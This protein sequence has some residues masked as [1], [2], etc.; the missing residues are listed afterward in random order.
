MSTLT[1]VPLPAFGQAEE[2]PPLPA[3]LYAGRLA[4]ARARMAEDGLDALVV[5]GDRE[6]FA[7]LAYLTGFD[8]RFEEALLLLDRDGAGKL[9]VGNECMGYLPD[10]ALGLDVELFQE[11]SLLGQPRAQ[12]RPLRNILSSFGIRRGV[13]V[14]C[15]GW[16]YFDSGLIAG[17]EEEEALDVP[18]Y[19]ADLLRG[20]CGV[21]K[22]VVNATAL[23]MNPYDGLRVVN[24][25]EQIAQFE[26][27]ATV[28]SAGVLDLLRHLAPGARE[29]NLERFLDSRGLPLSC[30][31][32]IG[33]GDKARRGLASASARRAVLGDVFTVAFGVTGGLTCRAGCIAR[34]LQDLSCELRNFYPR[35]AANYFDV[36][37]A[38]YGSLRVGAAGCGVFT[39]VESRRDA[40]LYDFAV[41]P[42]HFIHLDE[43]VH[44]P[45]CADGRTPLRSGM[46]L[47]AD[48]IPV[49]RGPFCYANAE[50]GVV[51]ADAALRAV[52][53]RQFPEMWERIRR[54]R[55]FV[56]D[57][58]GIRLDESV[59]PL[60]NLPAWLPPFALDL[61]K[62]F[63][64]AGSWP[65]RCRRPPP[66]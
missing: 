21:R 51:L 36:V 11:F 4:A 6:H 30:H 9:L 32:M 52:L 7:N 3:A 53:A 47:Q 55:A 62:V 44:S 63:T 60:G 28:T 19:L 48:I 45:F 59:L 49:S 37:C 20:L 15:V 40:S 54:R 34:G 41:N 14:G 42:G 5:Y 46:A 12:S 35:F 1:H 43:W 64:Q 8:P 57:A 29:Q 39:A 2:C 50:D 58:L 10:A 22:P 33:F 61:E 27:A 18:A 65:H 25:P 56:A 66:N 38:W 23:F 13:Q 26:Y 16:K 17:W 31:R 24:E